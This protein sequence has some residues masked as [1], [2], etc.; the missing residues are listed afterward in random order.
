[1]KIK[2][3]IKTVEDI[4]GYVFRDKNLITQALTHSS[5]RRFNRKIK[6]NEKLEFLGDSI[7]SACIT[8]ILYREHL[9]QNEGGLTKLRS[10]ITNNKI[11]SETIIKLNLGR[12]LRMGPG[13]KANE[14]ILSDLFESIVGAV[15]LDG[16]YH[17][18]FVMVRNVYVKYWQA[19]ADN[20]T[21]Y[22]SQMQEYTQSQL[23]VKPEYQVINVA[24]PAHRKEFTVGCLVNGK[25]E[26]VGKGPNKKQAEQMAAKEALDKLVVE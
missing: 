17:S 7:L 5:C 10:T 21:D 18:A 23:K 2:Q 24:G 22:K 13:Q 1:M 15:Y 11:L 20:N 14:S 6:D 25:V 8:D 16:G 9:A 26:G 12:S 4:I 19:V 3:R